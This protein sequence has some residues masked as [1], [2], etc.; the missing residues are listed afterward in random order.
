MERQPA[1]IT[2]GA[3]WFEGTIPTFAPEDAPVKLEFVEYE[4]LMA[5]D[6]GSGM[7]TGAFVV[8]RLAFRDV[9][10]WTPGI[11]HLDGQD[12]S[13]KL[14]YSGNAILVL[15]PYTMLYRMHAAN[16]IRSVHPYVQA[17]RLMMDRER[18]GQY[19][20]GPRRRFERC[21]RHGGVVFFC[22]KRL[23]RA[24][25]YGDALSLAAQGWPMMLTA[26][27]HKSLVC[28]RGRRAVQ[29]FELRPKNSFASVSSLRTAGEG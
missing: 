10:G 8:N 27:V 12:L 7:Y 20:G 15:S 5:K 1:A 17:G 4:S 28:I 22:T 24:G 21:S 2:S 11:W 25:L 23:F 14:G 19:P 3:R 6:R 18:T 26:I 16:C 29:T 9:G 13:A